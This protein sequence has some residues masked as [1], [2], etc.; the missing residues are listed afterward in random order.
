LVIAGAEVDHFMQLI[1][2]AV[3]RKCSLVPPARRNT[4]VDLIPFAAE[5][6]DAAVRSAGFSRS[7]H[8]RLGDY[9]AN[10]RQPSYAKLAE[11]VAL[12]GA[13]ADGNLLEPLNDVLYRHLLF[14][15]V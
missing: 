6:L 11:L 14:L 4:N 1:G 8:H 5:A 9:R 12:L 7:E 2:F 15:Q 13:R 3:P 10:R